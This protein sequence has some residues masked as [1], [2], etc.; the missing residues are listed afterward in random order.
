VSMMENFQPDPEW[1][2]GF[3][4]AGL[5]W[6]ALLDTRTKREATQSFE[7]GTFKPSP[8]AQ[9][10]MWFV[11]TEGDSEQ[12][13]SVYNDSDTISAKWRK[14]PD[15]AITLDGDLPA[16]VLRALSA[17]LGG[18]Q[19]PGMAMASK[20]A[21][22]CP[23]DCDQG[24]TCPCL[25]RKA[26][27]AIRRKA[28]LPPADDFKRTPKDAHDWL[29]KLPDGRLMWW[30]QGTD[31]EAVAESLVGQEIPDDS[32]DRV[33]V[34]VDGIVRPNSLYYTLTKWYADQDELQLLSGL[35]TKQGMT[36]PEVY[37][38]YRDTERWGDDSDAYASMSQEEHDD[39]QGRHNQWL[40]QQETERELDTPPDVT[41]DNR[42]QDRL[43]K[44]FDRTDDVDKLNRLYRNSSR[45]NACGGSC[46]GSCG[47]MG[48]D[49]N[50]DCDKR[51]ALLMVRRDYAASRMTRIASRFIEAARTN[52]MIGCWVPEEHA[53]GMALEGGEKPESL[54]LTVVMMGDMRKLGDGGTDKLRD[55]VKAF[56]G[57]SK[58]LKGKVSGL[59][60]FCNDGKDVLYASYDCPELPT[61]RQSLVDTLAEAGFEIDM[62]HGYSPHITLNYMAEGDDL[63]IQRV[64]SE[65]LEFPA[66][67]LCLGDDREH[68]DFGGEDE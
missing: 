1:V 22:E 40:E 32:I 17:H 65:D 59:G 24:Q 12:T 46:G 47:C 44:L 2:K 45:K 36:P 25:C 4:E 48:C 34:W 43:K 66:L 23:E 60:R 13:G 3:N 37:S 51:K 54:H 57:K 6:R 41:V 67:T 56:A 7:L 35:Y 26:V 33:G 50:C 8:T 19:A 64:D 18:H 28:A 55:V 21:C 9:S 42:S 58:K 39:M 14:G 27:R 20:L 10:D 53:K 68:F 11:A 31:R 38:T 29:M 5:Q 49:G 52:V 62:T 15:G 16:E 63:P 61:F 30:N